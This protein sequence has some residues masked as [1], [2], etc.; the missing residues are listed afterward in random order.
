[1][2]QN[3]PNIL[4]L[5]SLIALTTTPLL[6]GGCTAE[7]Q[8]TPAP[9]SR[10]LSG[11]DQ[12]STDPTKDVFANLKA[13]DLL[14]PITTSQGFD[15]A[16]VKT[17]QSDNG[18]GASKPRY[19]SVSVY[20]VPNAGIADLKVDGGTKSSTTIDGR[21]AVELKGNA[22]KGSCMIGI[23]VTETSRATVSIGLSNSGTNDEACAAV[24]SMA[25]Q[26][27][28]KLPQGN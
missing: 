10:A 24:K 25:E 17:Y 6:V 23:S 20:L 4:K 28:P 8:G 9:S 7:K 15:Q 22:G 14:E 12:K 19:G 13:C 26:I 21:E 27:A 18:C 2:R 1:M 11:T 16:E 3:R 5:V